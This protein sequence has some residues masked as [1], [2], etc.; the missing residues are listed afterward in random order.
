MT[1]YD[2][3]DAA[4]ADIVGHQ[5]T[6]DRWVGKWI[7]QKDERGRIVGK[8]PDPSDRN[9]YY[10]I[11]IQNILAVVQQAH[12]KHGV[13]VFF[14]GP[15]YDPEK[16]EKRIT[17]TQKDRYGN[18]SQTVYAN[19]HYRVE[20]VG[21][22][23]E[24][25]IQKE[26]QCEAKEPASGDKLGNKLLTNAMRSLYRSLYSIDADDSRD[27]EE[28]GTGVDSD[29]PLSP[30]EQAAND[31]F[32]GKADQ[33]EIKV[34]LRKSTECRKAIQD[35]IDEDP[36]GHGSH[37]I[38]GD[39]AGRFGQIDKWEPGTLVQCYKELRDAGAQLREVRL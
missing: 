6:K 4:Y 33:E 3:I 20:I 10:V 27:P 25:T 23:P 15:F 35:W 37:E 13:K 34:N 2:R 18:D 32:F 17:L 11:S 14:E 21:E 19:G 9:G 22:G 24:D 12:A 7:D 29:A 28:I 39:Y 26:V 38:I 5:F 30:R 36:L 31:P 8:I 1:I 16:Q